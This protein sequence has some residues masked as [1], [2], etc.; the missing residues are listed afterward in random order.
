MGPTP[1]SLKKSMYYFATPKL[2]TIAK[3]LSVQLYSLSFPP[4]SCLALQ[5]AASDMAEMIY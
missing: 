5:H 1:S 3:L 2:V 4:L